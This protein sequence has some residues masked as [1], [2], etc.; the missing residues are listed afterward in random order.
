MVTCMCIDGLCATISMTFSHKTALASR[1]YVFISSLIQ[2]ISMVFVICAIELCHWKGK[3]DS[4]TDDQTPCCTSVAWWGT[5][6][7]CSAPSLAMRCYLV[8][9]LF[10]SLHGSS[11]AI[12][13]T[14]AF[15]A[16]KKEMDADSADQSDG[17]TSGFDRIPGTAFSSW[18]SFMPSTLV[19]CVGLTKL[20]WG[21]D[22][23]RLSDW[24]QSA[25]VLT[26]FAGCMHWLYAFVRDVAR[27]SQR[28]NDSL[29]RRP[30]ATVCNLFGANKNHDRDYGRLND[31]S[32]P[33]ALD[34][35][36]VSELHQQ[37]LLS[38]S[39]GDYTGFMDALKAVMR[40]QK[41]DDRISLDVVSDKLQTP[42][43][44]AV[45]RRLPLFA[46]AL[47]DHG[48]SISV[49]GTQ[50]AIVVAAEAGDTT[51]LKRILDTGACDVY[52]MMEAM[53]ALDRH[54][55]DNDVD[56]PPMMAR[57]MIQCIENRSAPSDQVV[58]AKLM[59]LALACKSRN[60]CDLLLTCRLLN[61]FSRDSR[62]FTFCEG[63]SADD[64]AE[65]L[66]RL[67]PSAWRIEERCSVLLVALRCRSLNSAKILLG[68]ESTRRF[69]RPS[70]DDFTWDHDLRFDHP[71]DLLTWALRSPE[72]GPCTILGAVLDLGV[73]KFVA[74]AVFPL[75]I[76]DAPQ[77]FPSPV[78]HVSMK[79]LG[80]S[81]A[82]AD[83]SSMR[84][85]RLLTNTAILEGRFALIDGLS[86]DDPVPEEN[87]LA[88]FRTAR[89]LWIYSHWRRMLQRLHIAI[90]DHWARCLSDDR[91][92]ASSWFSPE[93]SEAELKE[94]LD[95]RL[96]IA[97]MASDVNVNAKGHLRAAVKQGKAFR[98]YERD[99]MDDSDQD[100]SSCHESSVRSLR[101][102]SLY[103][104]YDTRSPPPTTTE[105][106]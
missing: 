76:E 12:Y 103:A 36:E 85:L 64:S 89:Y 44:L 47:L 8:V 67:N 92:L 105:D 4:K 23:G 88:A 69:S 86:S 11:L 63:L 19:A 87:Q 106:D 72:K 51:M 17:H 102:R 43:S 18:I 32:F 33:H 73:A 66:T 26:A 37:L 5:I 57:Y 98:H 31:R 1:W 16:A 94:F 97:Y 9:R 34:T 77:N 84:L 56:V 79:K 68:L 71:L 59:D 20:L 52:S 90:D 40:R 13:H 21:V 75:N 100:T 101:T 82:N 25:A 74:F 48:A 55:A 50:P 83:R 61:R 46:G 49:P 22:C 42:L 99:E 35:T 95:V 45:A 41:Q 60:L 7:S 14:F 65:R 53:G 2:V 29:T 27:T 80:N 62:G 58:P 70:H 78:D 54:S 3:I 6:T 96:L 39:I 24:G 81:S 15:D 104:L 93:I 30:L 38:V 10:T 91:R 28:C